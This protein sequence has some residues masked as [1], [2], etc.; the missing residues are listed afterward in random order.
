MLH[1]VSPPR[2]PS[3]VLRPHRLLR[4]TLCS[5]VIIATVGVAPKTVTAAERPAL[6]ATVVS[7]SSVYSAAELFA[8]YRDQLGRPIT[9]ESAQA[10][11]AALVELYRR[12]GYARPELRIDDAL[13]A[14]GILRIEVLEPR[15]T[16]VTI[17]GPVG[18]Y[19]EQLER[20]A[21]GLRNSQP[22]RR[23]DLQQAV[24]KMRQLP[25]FTVTATTR[26]DETTAN[27]HELLVQADFAPVEGVLRM[28]NRGTEQ[29][30]RNFMLGQLV[31]NGLLGWEE[32]LGLL[33]AA[34]TD[35]EEYHG[36]GIFLDT[37]LAARGTRAM[38]MM[39]RSESAPN[40][41]PVNLTDEYTRERATL[42]ITEPL[43]RDRGWNLA[44]SGAFE[45]ED[46]T[47]DRDGLE[48]R[49]DRLRILEAGARLSWHSGDATQ[50][51]TTLELRQGLDGL[52]GGLEAA[53][54]PDDRRRSDFM[55]AQL[56]ISSLTRLN[57]SWSVR[58]D[59]FAQQTGYVLPDSERFKIGGDR[60]GRGFE[61]AEIAGDE[62]AGAKLELRRELTRAGTF[63][64]RT[65]AYGFYDIGAAW[66]QDRDGRESAATAGTGVALQGSR[67]TGY[68]E[69]AKP[70]THP[71][72]EGKRDT[73]V[74]AELSFR[75]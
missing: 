16:R 31:A 42:R 10:I 47:I 26:R 32:K 61:V 58:V 17:N 19:G 49:D 75:F 12:D 1:N 59:A 29:V 74:F 40:E 23:D 44:V 30:G 8:T 2:A 71:D 72:V 35:H 5:L 24:R 4:W 64:G 6:T 60:L 67:L 54:L 21:D 25:G 33:F 3:Q 69:V 41:S 51:V 9:R 53:D 15:I 46:L 27:G 20:I 7:G 34:A 18:R 37:P 39:F 63:F 11:T 43:Q 13:V 14:R 28:N 48:V 62:G 22:L 73:T 45:A 50:Y 70:L 52:G 66:K 65:S 56:Q 57:E 68:L 36:G 55:L 38:A